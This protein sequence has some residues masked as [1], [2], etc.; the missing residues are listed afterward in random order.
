MKLLLDGL[1]WDC[2]SPSFL[3]LSREHIQG[4]PRGRQ[5]DISFVGDLWMLAIVE[6]GDVKTAA[7]P[8]RDAAVAF[9]SQAFAQSC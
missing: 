8:S 7:Y 4:D 1:H 5:L 3:Q 2:P 6:D 9:V